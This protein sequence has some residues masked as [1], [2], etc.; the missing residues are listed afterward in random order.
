MYGVWPA[1]VLFLVVYTL[2]T[3]RFSRGALFNIVIAAF[4][5]FFVAFGLA[6]P[7]HDSLHLHA[8]ADRSMLWV[9]QGK[10]CSDACSD[11]SSC[12]V[13][14]ECLSCSGS[15]AACVVCWRASHS[16]CMICGCAGF[17]GAVGMVRNWTYTLLFIAGE[18]WGDVVLSLLFWGLANELT[19]MSEA[20]TLYPLFGMVRC[21]G[22]VS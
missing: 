13:S 11:T 15:P 12:C 16:A 1:S 9:P 18:L 22:H 10:P 6:C 21:P 7:L 14:A 2:G 17:G 20:P 5:V 19:H 3:Q 4:L 8:F